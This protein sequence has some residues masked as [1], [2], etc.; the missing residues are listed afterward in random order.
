M[1]YMFCLSV[2]LS[3]IADLFGSQ[4]TDYYNTSLLILFC[5][6]ASAAA[7]QLFY[8]LFFYLSVYLKEP[9]ETKKNN[10]PVSIIICARNEAENLKNFLP[11]VLE[12]DYPDFE[13]VVVNDCSEDNSYDILGTFLKK[14]PNLR[15]STVNKDPKFSHNKK[16]AQFIGIKAA[17][18]EILLF[19]D[20]DCHPESNKW[21]EGMTSHFEEK[22]DFVLGYG[23]YLSEKGLLNKYIRYDSFTIAMQY[24]GMAIRRVPY[25]GV[26]RNM[27]YR[28]S[29]FFANKG[30]GSHNHIVSGDDDLLVNT[31]ATGKNTRVEYNQE[32]HTRSVPSSSLNEW[33]SQKKRHLTTA[34]FYKPRDK[35]LLI[36]EPFSRVI[37]YSALIILLSFLFLWPWVLSV[38]VIRLITQIIIYTL[39][40]KKLNEPGLLAYLLIFDIFS[41]LINGII[42]LSNNRILSGKNRWK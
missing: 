37:F 39:V 1:K 3:N 28:R 32:T 31:I 6:F 11:S 26:G 23:G 16:F 8:Y 18:N 19:T 21:L 30:F 24:L 2:N 33:I 22:V 40:R 36:T 35:F 14:Y 15:I 13:V 38:F 10:Q 42:F 12:Q 34:P 9:Y 17:K 7:V 41:P 20:A 4:M 25:M 27:S 29:V 5:I